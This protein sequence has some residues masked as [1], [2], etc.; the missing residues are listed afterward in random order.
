MSAC[1]L[2]LPCSSINTLDPRSHET[3]LLSILIKS[4]TRV[5]EIIKREAGKFIRQVQR[6]MVEKATLIF[7]GPRVYQSRRSIAISSTNPRT[8]NVNE[9]TIHLFLFYSAINT[10][11]RRFQRWERNTHNCNEYF[12]TLPFL[13]CIILS[14]RVY[15]CVY[16]RVR[17]RMHYLHSHVFNNLLCTLSTTY[18]LTESTYIHKGSYKF[19]H[20]CYSWIQ[21]PTQSITKNNKMNV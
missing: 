17:T 8:H 18:T 4:V 12:E 14:S 10:R 7:C 16:V 6:K 5:Y 21:K 9:R 11:Y 15:I 1:G 13:S 3:T 20:H 2:S 19:K